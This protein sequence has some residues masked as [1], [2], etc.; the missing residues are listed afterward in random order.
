MLMSF[1]CISQVSLETGALLDLKEWKGLKGTLADQD[2]QD[3]RCVVWQIQEWCFAVVTVWS[4]TN[5]SLVKSEPSHI[6]VYFWCVFDIKY[7]EW[8][9]KRT[10]L[11][12]RHWLAQWSCGTDYSRK[13]RTICIEKTHAVSPIVQ[14]F[15]LQNFVLIRII[16]RENLWYWP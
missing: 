16:K 11:T 9:V 8:W 14:T 1:V 5:V 7:D 12:R 6:L 10:N 13:F 15:G 2:N 4:H 3:Y